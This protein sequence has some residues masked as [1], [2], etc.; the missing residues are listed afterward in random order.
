MYI[1]EENL[2]SG[3]EGRLL[4]Q[5]IRRLLFIGHKNLEKLNLLN[6]TSWFTR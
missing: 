4:R 5:G 2:A 1:Q 3:Q 6:P